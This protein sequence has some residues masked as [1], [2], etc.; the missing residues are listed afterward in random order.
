MVPEK[1]SKAVID[2]TEQEYKTSFKQTEI[3]NIPKDWDVVPLNQVSKVIDSLHQ[4][5]EFS[6]TGLPMVRV[7]DIK[8]GYLDL[9]NACRVS[10]EVYQKFTK[11]Y[12]PQ[13]GDIIVSRVGSYGM[14]A[15]VDTDEKFCLGQNTAII[16]PMINEKYL[17][18]ILQS[19][20]IKK[21][22]DNQVDGSSQK[23]LSLKNIRDL[24]I[25]VTRI[26]CEQKKIADILSSVDE[27]IASTQA[28]IDQTRKVKQGLLQQLLT[29]GIGHTRFKESAIGKIPEEWEVKPLQ[30][31]A[32]IQ[33]GLAKG[34]KVQ[35]NSVE[36]PYLRVANVQDG[37]LDLSEI[38]MIRVAPKEIDRYRLKPGDVLLTEGGDLDKLGRGDIWRGQIEMC[39]HQNHI[40]AVRP[41]L[42]ILLP[43]F[44]AA[45]TGSNYGKQYFLNCGKQT[46]NLA[47]INSTQLKNFPAIV[48]PMNEQKAIIEVLDS[49]RSNELA[50]VLELESLERLKRGLMQDL[51]TGRVRI[52]N[53]KL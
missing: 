33:T 28:V 37:Y 14:L 30:E 4:T 41:N 53:N 21:Q 18:Y 22:I 45:Q 20:L 34:K 8:G 15:Y 51:L 27:A 42:N 17:F 26:I 32:T 31:I 46:T 9:K 50:A 12:S 11:S 49:V 5:P 7:T 2:S 43:E 47:S 3:G 44:L 13:K 36:L 38:K 29:K 25:A 10:E 52:N 23:T 16:N 1:L 39:L 35:G 6:N 19:S 48:P 24:K 40:F